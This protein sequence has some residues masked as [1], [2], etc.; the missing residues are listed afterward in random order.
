MNAL[1]VLDA[2]EDLAKS[3]MELPVP[4]RVEVYATIRS[5]IRDLED[6][7]ARHGRG[8][9]ACA[10]A[11]AELTLHAQSI[12]QL[13]DSDDHPDTQHLVWLFRTLDRLRSGE[14]FGRPR[15]GKHRSGG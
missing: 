7:H 5:L 11:L 10:E 14:C 12:A 4:G 15:T 1:T 3:M 8:D 9:D 2:I 13:D 6:A